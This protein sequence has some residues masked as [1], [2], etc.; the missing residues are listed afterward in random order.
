[1]VFRYFKATLKKSPGNQLFPL[2]FMIPILLLVMINIMAAAGRT[3]QR[4]YFHQNSSFSVMA[5]T[6]SSFEQSFLP[7]IYPM[8]GQYMREYSTKESPFYNSGTTPMIY[9]CKDPKALTFSY[10]TKENLIEGELPDGNNYQTLAKEG[11]FP[12]CISYDSARET[13]SWLG[14][15]LHMVIQEE[16]ESMLTYK[17]KIIGIL[18]PDGNKG[19]VSSDGNQLPSYACALVDPQTYDSLP[20]ALHFG[21]LLY[22]NFLNEPGT[23]DGQT[24]SITMEEMQKAIL[25]ELDKT[26]LMIT[27]LFSLFIII[28]LCCAAY[29]LLKYKIRGDAGILRVMG[30]RSSGVLSIHFFR[31]A[32][33]LLASV[34]LSALFIKLIYLPFIVREYYSFAFIGAIGLSILAIGLG[35]CACIAFGLRKK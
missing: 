3:Y 5:N 17:F 12:I 14:D 15:E 2:V 22:C 1:M 19:R 23:L 21:D 31:T 8:A 27:L 29:S 20:K 6:V 18:H 13:N 35:T 24:S 4:W 26:Q 7:V 28:I 33:A 32:S 25:D 34:V 10:F 9:F 16:E 30:M 11:F